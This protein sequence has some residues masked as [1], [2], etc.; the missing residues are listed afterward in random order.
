MFRIG[1]DV[2]GTFTDFLLIENGGDNRVYKVITTPENP[3]RGVLYGM[4]MMAQELGMSTGEFLQNVSTIVHGTTITTNATLTQEG[5]KTGFIT[6]KGFRDCLNMRRG[7]REK[8][9]NPKQSPPLPLVPR[10]LTMVVEERIDCDG[11]EVIPLHEQGVYEAIDLFKKEQVESVAV[12][13]LF[14]FFNASHEE[15]IGEILR[16]NMPDVYI[17]LSSEVLPQVRVYERNS[18]TALNA[19]VGPLLDRYL[20]ELHTSLTREG[21]KG[22]LL[23]MQSNG[24]TM[25]LELASKFAV[26]TLLSGPASGPTAGLFYAEPHNNGNIITIDMG[27][28]S[29]DVCLIKDHAAAVTMEGQ[30]GNYSI[31]TPMIDI[32]TIGAGGGSIAWIDSGGMLRVGP[33]SAGALPGP[34]CYGLGGV[35]PTV[36]DATLILGYLDPEFFHGGKLKLKAELAHQGIEKLGE[37]LGLDKVSTADGILKI[38]LMNMADGVMEVSVKRGYDPREFALVVAGGAGPIHA[39]AIAK[40]LDIPLIIVPRES[41]VFCAAGMLLS[42]LKHDY[43]RTYNAP[44][45]E[46]DLAKI[47]ELY[48][49]MQYEALLTLKSEGIP[50]ERVSIFISADLRYIG[51]FNDVE[52]PWK[53]FNL[54]DTVYLLADAFH[55]R[56]ESLYGYSMPGSSVEFINLRL[57]ALGVTDKHTLSKYPYSSGDPSPALKGVRAAYFEGK[58]L[59]TPVYNGL[60]LQ[61][62]NLVT[63]PGIVEQINTTIIVSP[64]YRL[65]CDEYNN[66]IIQ[67]E[68][69]KG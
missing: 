15:R 20:K 33:K 37:K 62:G 32:H 5:A 6:T 65:Y 48:Q 4:K 61:Y 13:L 26:N 53:G 31:A 11:Q 23:I 60:K 34:I 39:T 41:S 55:H 68:S 51:Q 28:T 38:V 63:G 45:G 8:K 29:F 2:G 69:F 54:G 21:F 43:V 14:S 46:H 35:D 40:V 67:S 19:Y 3:A 52:V 47:K 49:Q 7:L 42:D 10:Y 30:I 50:Q 36:T 66:Y 25:S 24:G 1:I 44:L 56:H 22:T 16:T 18:T 17:T 12:S 64:G 9:Y 59:E 27:G 58:F 57:T